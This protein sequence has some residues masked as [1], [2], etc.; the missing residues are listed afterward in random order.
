MVL[1][2]T[3]AKPKVHAG[4]LPAWQAWAAQRPV[5]RANALRQLLAA[6]RCRLPALPPAPALLLASR[7][8]RLVD[9]RSSHALAAAW[10]GAWLRLHDTAGHDLPL[11]DSPWVKAQVVNWARRVGLA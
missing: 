6:A 2:L 9:W 4:A 5:S 8:D 7:G 1:R 11:D 3:S 10:P